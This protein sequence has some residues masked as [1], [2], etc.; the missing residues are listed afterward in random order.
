MREL[1]MK[2]VDSTN[3]HSIGYDKNEQLMIIELHDGTFYKFEKV[4]ESVNIELFEDAFRED[5]F[6]KKVKYEYD[7][8][9]LKVLI[10]V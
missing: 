7:F 10:N 6:V 9:V 4:P 8:E 5:I 1:K 3:V 2:T